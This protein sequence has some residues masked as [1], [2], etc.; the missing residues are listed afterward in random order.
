MMANGALSNR[1][2]RG[3]VSVLLLLLLNTYPEV[4][5]MFYF[6]VTRPVR[7]YC[8]FLLLECSSKAKHSVI[9]YDQ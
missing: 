2:S 7:K 4:K 6:I 9:A 5:F 1:R 3:K 8:E